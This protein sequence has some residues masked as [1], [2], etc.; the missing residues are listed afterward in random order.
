LNGLVRLVGTFFACL[1]L[2]GVGLRAAGSLGGE[3]DRQ[4]LDGLLS[5]PLPNREILWAKWQ[6]SLLS[7]RKLW[8]FLALIW[9]AGLATGGINPL[10]L[11]ALV[12]DWFIT[13]TFL[14]SLGMW[15]SLT[16][17]TTQRAITL[18][19]A[20]MVGLS[21]GPVLL[22]LFFNL[23]LWIMSDFMVQ[24]IADNAIWLGFLAWVVLPLIG[25]AVTLIVRGARRRD[26]RKFWSP[27]AV[28]VAGLTPTILLTLLIVG[29]LFFG[30][31]QQNQNS[32]W[33]GLGDLLMSAV[34]PPFQ[35]WC[36]TFYEGD[37]GPAY[38]G[39]YG[40]YTSGVFRE[41]E[42]SPHLV[43]LLAVGLGQVAYGL[44]AL[45]LWE[46]TCRRFPKVTGRMPV[47]PWKEPIRAEVT[48]GWG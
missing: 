21:L 7:G 24:L 15:F 46:M 14:A 12:A 22:G 37:W 17:R 32:N 34:S 13:A 19:L 16:C 27:L 6:A 42:F 5:A 35:L 9:L 41:L 36:V 29:A 48:G 20:V 26:D 31:H 8:W 11:P 25:L 45:V 2:V 39:G 28:L 10:A 23:V 18:M 1:L 33:L 30:Q 47:E 3:R 43:K 40:G 4:T 44:A 38:Y